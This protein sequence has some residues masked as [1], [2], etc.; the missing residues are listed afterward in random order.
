MML[1]LILS[2]LV[3]V[4]GWA[5]VMLGSMP[6]RPIQWRMVRIGFTLGVGGVLAFI[7]SAFLVFGGM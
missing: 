4:V 3:A 2:N 5:M 7:V 6:D 1:L